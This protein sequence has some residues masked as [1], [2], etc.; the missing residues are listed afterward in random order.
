MACVNCC[1]VDAIS[2]RMDNNGYDMP[3]VDRERCIECGQCE[4]ICPIG[5]SSV[6]ETA[7]RKAFSAF[8]QSEE[9]V[10][11]SSS[12][13]TYYAL[14]Q[15][16]LRQGGIAFGCF[17]DIEKKEARLEDTDHVPLEALLTSKYVESRIGLGL[18]E[19]RRHL[20]SGRQ[21]LFC[22]TPCQAAGLKAYLGKDYENLLLADFSCGAVAANEYLR[23]H[24]LNLEKKAGARAVQVRFRDKHYEWGQYCL[25]V[26][27]ENGKRYRK[28]AMSDPYFFCFLRSSMQRFGCQSC[29]FSVNHQS[30]LCLGDFWR[31]DSFEVERNDRKGLSLIL[32]M[33][34]KGERA[35]EKIS[36][37]MHM[38]ELD[39]K[40]A[41]YQL[42][43]RHCPEEKLPEIEHAMRTAKE[44]GV[45]ELRR[46]LLPL[47]RRAFF[48]VR[49]FTMDHPVIAAIL[50]DLRGDGQIEKKKAKEGK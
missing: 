7:P 26:D 36:G 49:Q 17:Y 34:E 10:R 24:L 15:E 8:H 3:D 45:A 41:S 22:S 6:P 13:G 1:P 37:G 28:T 43:P 21:V 14:A 48:A 32:A 31:C 9:A 12:G 5:A 11:I 27:F 18:R 33:T 4:A 25:T 30:D 38:E 16:V 44:Q 40:E 42:Q 23:Q 29:R 19:V 39:V 47:K 20:D 35:L 50:P 46:Q 2:V